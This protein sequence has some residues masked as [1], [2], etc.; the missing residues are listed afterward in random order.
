VAERRRLE[1]VRVSRG[2][3]SPSYIAGETL[4][5][6]ANPLIQRAESGMNASVVKAEQIAKQYKPEKPM[7]MRQEAK[8]LLCHT[9]DDV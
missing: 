5:D 7:V 8:S 3:R 9:C 1:T 2:L 4:P 6:L